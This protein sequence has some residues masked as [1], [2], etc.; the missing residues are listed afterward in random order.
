MAINFPEGQ[1]P[2]LKW[3]A[4][5]GDNG[6]TLDDDGISS[7]N[8]NQQGQYTIYFDGNMSNNDYALCAIGQYEY[9]CG[10]AQD[11][12]ANYGTSSCIV[13]HG[14]YGSGTSADGDHMSVIIVGAA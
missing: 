1:I 14:R 12:H 5:D 7:I 13:W 2:T 11:N 4:F 10:P 8:R 9:S 6:S 3:V